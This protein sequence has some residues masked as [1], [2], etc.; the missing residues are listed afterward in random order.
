MEALAALLDK[1]Q[2]KTVGL[3]REEREVM[4]AKME[5]MEAKQRAEVDQLRKAAVV[6]KR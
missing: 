2:D 5:R 4:E 3:M 6:G 1:Q